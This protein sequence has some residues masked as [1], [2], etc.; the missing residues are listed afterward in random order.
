MDLWINILKNIKSILLMF[1]F[2]FSLLWCMVTL[3]KRKAPPNG[4]WEALDK[5]IF[6]I[7][8]KRL[9]QQNG[10]MSRMV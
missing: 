1:L 5:K 8:L 9:Y 6:F 2:T 3:N 7:Q 10:K 4:N